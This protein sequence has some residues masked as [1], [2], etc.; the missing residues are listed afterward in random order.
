[1]SDSGR[2]DTPPKREETQSGAQTRD[3]GAMQ[4]GMKP[5]GSEARVQV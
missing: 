2:A 1:M 3:D 5:S 4:A